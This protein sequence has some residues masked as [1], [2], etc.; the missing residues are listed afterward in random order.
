MGIGKFMREKRADRVAEAL[1]K[2]S[3]TVEL[4]QD[5]SFY[6]VYGEGE[7]ATGNRPYMGYINL[8][9]ANNGWYPSLHTVDSKWSLTPDQ[10]AQSGIL[11]REFENQRKRW[12]GHTAYAK[13]EL[14]GAGA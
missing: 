14:A 3:F 12:E 6:H 4:E 7:D 11:A 5:G 13:S 10:I 9:P 2:K 8:N 1:R